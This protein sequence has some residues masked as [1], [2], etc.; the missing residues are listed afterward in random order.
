MKSGGREHIIVGQGRVLPG[1]FR[2]LGTA[3]VIAFYYWLFS[4]PY[5]FLVVPVGILFS[6][7]IPIIWSTR[8]ILEIDVEKKLIH[9]TTWILGKKLGKPDS[10]ERLNKIFVNKVNTSQRMTSYGGNVHTARDT[11]YT[12]FLLYDEHKKVEL[13]TSKDKENLMSKVKAVADKLALTI[14]DNT[15]IR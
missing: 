9:D 4:L 11:S 7:S 15:Q 3:I 5:P 2:F 10:Y 1:Q 14:Q 8:Y 12:A 6:F 13:Q